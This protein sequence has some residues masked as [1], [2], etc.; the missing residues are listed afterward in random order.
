M[1]QPGWNRSTGPISRS[2]SHWTRRFPWAEKIAILNTAAKTGRTD[3][4]KGV[5]SR[6]RLR[7]DV[8]FYETRPAWEVFYSPIHWVDR[9]IRPYAWKPDPTVRIGPDMALNQLDR[10]IRPHVWEDERGRA[11]NLSVD[12]TERSSGSPTRHSHETVATEGTIPCA[13]SLSVVD[14]RRLELPDHFA[15]FV[16]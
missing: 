1:S 7:T 16:T 11:K 9:R 15:T 3:C 4:P 2:P 6:G 14:R 12:R 5:S 8:K 10:R 13:T